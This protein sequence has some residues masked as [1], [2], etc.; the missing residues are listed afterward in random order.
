LPTRSCR[1]VWHSSRFR[2]CFFFFCFFCFLFFAY[3]HKTRSLAPP[4]LDLPYPSIL[5][6]STS[7]GIPT[8]LDALIIPHP[9][10]LTTSWME[11]LGVELESPDS[12]VLR[13]LLP[14][15]HDL[16][17]AAQGPAGAGASGYD[18][19]K[20]LEAAQP[21]GQQAP[22]VECGGCGRRFDPARIEKHRNA[23]KGARSSGSSPSRPAA[24]KRRPPPPRLQPS[25]IPTPGT[26]TAV[27]EE[28][29]VNHM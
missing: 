14:P 28:S 21:P 15:A 9:S 4:D 17:S 10:R 23:C 26:G 11:A 18:L 25:Q 20:M 13:G 16:V 29:H 5:C 6:Q 24:T 19:E 3:R 27:A 8:P 1:R 22:L 7:T 2:L 12:L